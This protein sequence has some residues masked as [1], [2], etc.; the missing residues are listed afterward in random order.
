MLLRYVLVIASLVALGGAGAFAAEESVA[1]LYA[2]LSLPLPTTNLV[3]IC[4]GFGCLYRTQVV[5]TA[6]DRAHVKTLL[7]PGAASPAAERRAIANAVAWFDRRIGPAA[8]TTHR[9]ARAGLE[10]SAGEMDCIDTSS[11]N[12]SLFLTLKLL[13][14]LHHHRVEPPV[15]RGYL[16]DARLPHTT[17]VL[18]EV[19]SG[20]RWAIDNWTHNYAEMPDVEPLATWQS[21]H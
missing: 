14:L 20:A 1:E 10:E 3:V 7:A 15:S 21:E 16:I 6:A 4:H 17:A 13:S 18:A 19:K 2:E 8:G 11:N 12:T 9:T 5:L